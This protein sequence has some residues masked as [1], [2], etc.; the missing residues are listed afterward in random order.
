VPHKDPEAHQKYQQ[1]YQRKYYERNRQ[2]AI[3]NTIKNRRSL[4][5]VKKQWLFEHLGR[6]CLHCGYDNPDGL[7]FHHT[8][9]SLKRHWGDIRP[10]QQGGSGIKHQRGIVDYSWKDLKAKVDTLEVL[11]FNCHNVHHAEERK[12]TR[13]H[14]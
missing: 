7:S 10:G 5:I 2:K 3:E 11:C 14:A 8:D 4:R 12:T 13:T 9:P 1:K 6:E